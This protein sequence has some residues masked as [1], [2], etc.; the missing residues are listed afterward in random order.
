MKN[1]L[2]TEQILRDAVATARTATGHNIYAWCA[3][4]K[5]KS[6]MQVHAAICQAGIERAASFKLQ[7]GVVSHGH[8]GHWRGLVK[9]QSIID[10]AFG[11]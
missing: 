8:C 7:S 10:A 1:L 11:H 9:P 2:T 3:N 5:G 4:N 6:G